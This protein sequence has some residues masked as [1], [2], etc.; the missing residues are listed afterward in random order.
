MAERCCS[1]PPSLLP[2]S[3]F[4]V[5]S[6]LLAKEII[7]FFHLFSQFSC[8]LGPLLLTFHLHVSRHTLC[9]LCRP[10]IFECFSSAP[11][12]RPCRLCR[13]NLTRLSTSSSWCSSSR[14]TA[15]SCRIWPRC[16][17]WRCVGKVQLKGLYLSFSSETKIRFNISEEL[18]SRTKW[19]RPTPSSYS[20]VLKP[21]WRR[22]RQV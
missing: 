14:S 17:K 12:S 18:Q 20:I 2:L 13:D 5:S 10:F 8:Y 19:L 4:L 1:F 16:N 3:L 9:L 6:D 11:P 22:N 21:G 7:S 15:P